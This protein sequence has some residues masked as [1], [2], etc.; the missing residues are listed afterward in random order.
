MFGD[1]PYFITETGNHTYQGYANNWNGVTERVQAANAPRFFLEFF[2]R[3]IKRTF[4][5]Q[6]ADLRNDQA[7]SED[8]ENF[9]GLIDGA[10]KPK[11]SFY[12]VKNMINILKDPESD[13][14]TTKPI[15]YTITGGK[16]D[17]HHTLLEKHNGNIYII[18]WVEA[19]NFSAVGDNPGYEKVVPLQNLTV[20]LNSITPSAVNKY[21]N[22]AGA[23]GPTK[24]SLVASKVIPVAVNDEIVILEIT[25]L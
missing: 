1:K 4:F 5:Y 12:A 24:A 19:P 10:G 3:G 16:S 22:M 21:T 25:P 20:T 9:C 8:P 7:T 17:V 14:F 11:P 6:F 18:L 2:N 15:S 13:L 23:S